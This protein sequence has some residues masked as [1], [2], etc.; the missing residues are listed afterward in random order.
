MVK[1][2]KGLYLEAWKFSIYISLPI[3]ASVYHSNPETQ[4]YWADYWRF[5]TYPENP[6]TNVKQKI[7]E[8]AKQKEEQR[9]QHVAY[10]QQLQALQKSAERSAKYGAGAIGGGVEASTDEEPKSSWLRR[11]GGWFSRSSSHTEE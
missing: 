8:L 6:N 10:Q 9:E 1:G 5:I 11:L 7:Q 4:K 2:K 3:I